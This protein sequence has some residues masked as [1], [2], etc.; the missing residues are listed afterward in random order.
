MNTK[1]AYKEKLLDPRWQKKRLEILQR[2]DFRCAYCK[3]ETK[4]LHVHHFFYNK[5][6]NPWDAHNDQLITLCD[7]CHF[8]EHQK[9]S[10]LERKMISALQFL[11]TSEFDD[12][13]IWLLATGLIVSENS[14]TI[15]NPYEAIK[16]VILKHFNNK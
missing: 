7:D 12:A 11:A 13:I 8:I 14:E 1:Q 10:E 2:D 3:N 6:G 16:E 15:S 9:F 4:T 5:N